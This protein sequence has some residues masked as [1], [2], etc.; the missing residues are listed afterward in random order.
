MR[1]VLLIVVAVVAFF[2]WDNIANKGAYTVQ[3]TRKIAQAE[4][5]HGLVTLN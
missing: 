3:L 5:F 2:T 4:N 1:T